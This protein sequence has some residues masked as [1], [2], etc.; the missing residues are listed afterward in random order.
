[1]TSAALHVTHVTASADDG[2]KPDNTIDG[3]VDSRWSAEGEQWIQWDL[4][5]VRSVQGVRIAFFKGDSRR[6]RFDLEVSTTDGGSSDRV[7]RDRQSTGTTTEFETFDFAPVPARYVRYVGHGNS[8][9]EWNSLTEVEVLGTDGA[10]DIQTPETHTPETHTPDTGSHLLG[11]HGESRVVT[12]GQ[13]PPILKKSPLFRVFAGSPEQEVF[14]EVFDK[15]RTI[16]LAGFSA[17]GSVPIR[18]EVLKPFSGSPQ[19]SPKSR[20]LQH[21]VDGNSI[22]FT[23]TKPENLILFVKTGGGDPQPLYL[24]ADPLEEKAPAPGTPNVRHVASGQHLDVGDLTLRSDETLYIA[25]G[26]VVTGRIT[27]ENVANVTIKGRG[28]LRETTSGKGT[29][30]RMDG[31][32]NVTVEGIH[33]RDTQEDW[34]T[35]YSDCDGVMIRNVKI[36]SCG[37][38]EDGI[39]PDASSNV[40]I[41]SCLISTGDDCIAI[42]IMKEDSHAKMSTIRVLRTVLDSYPGGGGGDGVK[43]GTETF[44]DG[45]ISDVLVEDCDVVRAFGE[46]S[47]DGH[48]A[49]SIVHR[50]KAKISNVR[51]RNIRVED[52]KHNNF[53]IRMLAD[54]TG[55]TI[56]GDASKGTVSDVELEDISWAPQRDLNLVGAGISNVRFIRCTVAGH[57]LT[58]IEQFHRVE[59][60]PTNITFSQ[61]PPVV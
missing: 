8:D 7:L 42:K 16:H 3:N 17:S 4:G 26:A 15:R 31:C 24:W 61:E 54:K 37:V 45:E 30:I 50:P 60:H 56:S 18:V 11:E 2:N 5:E 28:M 21:T 59:G 46:N 29:T 35:R 22:R 12:Y 13:P 23:I 32:R 49:F 38:R 14:T 1:M 44:G 48:S 36:F 19:I 33:V 34:S 20:K 41:D 57:P 39:D 51:Y 53:E 10:P 27:A 55:N 43:I 52:V 47:F 40:T 58:S 6:A 25:G 9:T